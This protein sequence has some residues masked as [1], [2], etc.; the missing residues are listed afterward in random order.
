[1]DAHAEP[2]AGFAQI[3]DSCPFQRFANTLDDHRDIALGHRKLVGGHRGAAGSRRDDVGR[4]HDA[5]QI[6]RLRLDGW[7]CLHDLLLGRAVFL[8]EVGKRNLFPRGFDFYGGL[9]WRRFDH[10]R[11]GFLLNGLRL[12]F[13]RLRFG[14]RLRLHDGARSGLWDVQRYGRRRN[15]RRRRGYGGRV[16]IAGACDQLECWWRGIIHPLRPPCEKH[17]QPK[18]RYV[19]ERGQTRRTRHGT[20]GSTAH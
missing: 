14:Q 18:Y 3:V 20:G 5:V 19:E 13:G 16:I 10:H 17:H 1:M 12:R 8:G 11:S 9:F 4:G 7:R 15:R 2:H 6:D